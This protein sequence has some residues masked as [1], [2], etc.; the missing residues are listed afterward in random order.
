MTLKELCLS[1]T[2]L[3]RYFIKEKPINDCSYTIIIWIV[4]LYELSIVPRYSRDTKQWV[5]ESFEMIRTICT[6]KGKR[7]YPGMD[8]Q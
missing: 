3:E 1:K 5:S 7:A 2:K 4:N 8:A 6:Y